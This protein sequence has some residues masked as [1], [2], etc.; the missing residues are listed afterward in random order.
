MTEATVE[1]SH[2]K[3]SSTAG[4]SKASALTVISS[5]TDTVGPDNQDTSFTTLGGETLVSSAQT[6]FGATN[7]TQIT[8]KAPVEQLRT[9][10]PEG[11]GLVDSL[12]RYHYDV[13]RSAAIHPFFIMGNS[14]RSTESSSALYSGPFRP[15]ALSTTLPVS[16]RVA[17]DYI[18]ERLEQKWKGSCLNE[19]PKSEVE[20]AQE[21]MHELGGKVTSDWGAW[22]EWEHAS[23]FT[24]RL[25][26]GW[27]KR[28]E[29]RQWVKE[30][31]AETKEKIKEHLE[32]EPTSEEYQSAWALAFLQKAEE[33]A[34]GKEK[35]VREYQRGFIGGMAAVLKEKINVGEESTAQSLVVG[36]QSK[37]AG[38]ES[39]KRSKNQEPGEEEDNMTILNRLEGKHGAES[40]I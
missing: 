39:K 33:R 12:P 31:E 10:L 13:I 2:E 1:D 22:A 28:R 19:K 17:H 5:H 11:D 25:K 24:D 20:I 26:P 35:E 6:S 15:F 9:V 27:V 7:T 36:A 38:R 3:E 21:V 4:P 34:K 37:K 30:W 23:G 14:V 8:S 29:E 16:S 18:L 32:R 40:P